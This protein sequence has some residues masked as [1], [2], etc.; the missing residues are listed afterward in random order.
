MA[1]N[2]LPAAKKEKRALATL[3]QDKKVRDGFNAVANE[4]L[5]ADKMVRL[6]TSALRT[7]P[8]LA[9]C[10][11]ASVLGCMMTSMSLG[12]EPNTALGHAYLIPYKRN[13][14]T[15]QGWVT[16]MECQFQIGYKGFLALA[17]RQPNIISI[18]AE[19]VRENDEF[20]HS[21][22]SQT[23]IR[24]KKALRDA[25]EVI[26]AYCIVKF[27]DRFKNEGE[28]VTLLPLDEIHRI[29]ENSDTWKFLKQKA[30]EA[31]ATQKD[32]AKLADTPWEKWFDRMAR[33]TAV[34]Q[35]AKM[36]DLGGH[37]AAAAAVDGLAEAERFNAGEIGKKT[38]EGDYEAVQN[39]TDGIEVPEAIEHDEETGEITEPEPEAKPEAKKKAAAKKKTEKKDP[40]PEP[41][42]DAEPDD[43]SEPDDEDLPDPDDDAGLFGDEG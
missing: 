10:D 30:S 43:D 27:I 12:L 22:G 8:K 35:A 4:H 20:E 33:K 28:M 25:G 29:R 3:L 34:K 6:C 11:P 14:K 36:L 32:K 26:A 21:L 19:V 39:V 23:V 41:E 31:N 18:H 24:H 2:N 1:E 38:I 15:P 7:T 13:V 9:E 42:A 40:E 37:M 16:R 5:S 17:M